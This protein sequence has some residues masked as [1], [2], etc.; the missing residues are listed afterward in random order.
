MNLILSSLLTWALADALYYFLGHRLVLIFAIAAVVQIAIV[1][2]P[3][4][5]APKMKKKK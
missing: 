5:S 1:L 4:L 2:F 3:K